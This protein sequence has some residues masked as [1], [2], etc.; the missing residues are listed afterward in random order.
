MRLAF[1][2]VAELAITPLQDMLRL[3][4]EARMNTP[5]TVEHNW[6]W[7]LRP[8]MLTPGLAGGVRTL[9]AAYGRCE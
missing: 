4:S 5:G 3:G 8:K 2:S 9:T 7:R 6:G 1:E